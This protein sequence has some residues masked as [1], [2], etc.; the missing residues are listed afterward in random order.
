MK[1]TLPVAVA[2]VIVAVKIAEDPYADGFAEEV[3]VTV[4]VAGFTA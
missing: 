1:A 2:G 4:V 3:T